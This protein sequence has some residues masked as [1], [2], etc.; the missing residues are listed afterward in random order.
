MHQD[1]SEDALLNLDS[2]DQEK[3]NKILKELEEERRK[4]RE[5]SLT[6]YD[7]LTRHFVPVDWPGWQAYRFEVSTDCT[8]F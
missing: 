7:S 4:A 2:D 5:K 8:L 6:V 3:A 1:E